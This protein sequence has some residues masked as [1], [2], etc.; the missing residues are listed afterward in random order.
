MSEL[1]T[2]TAIIENSFKISG[3]GIVVDLKHSEEGL[4][5]NTVL[6]SKNLKLQWIVKARVLFDHAVHKQIIFESEAT[7]YLLCSFNSIDKKKDSIQSIV[8]KEKQ[9]IFQ[10]YLEPVKHDNKPIEGELL[11]LNQ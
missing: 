7:E 3:R 4:N 11:V 8:N 6:T 10:Y 1:K 2:A 9:G 5:K